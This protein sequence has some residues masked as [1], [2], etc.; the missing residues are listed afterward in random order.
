M[1]PDTSFEGRKWSG[2]HC[3]RLN[4][5]GQRQ[6]FLSDAFNFHQCVCAIE[7]HWVGIL[8]RKRP[9]R[10]AVTSYLRNSHRF[11]QPTGAG[12]VSVIAAQSSGSRTAFVRAIFT[13]GHCSSVKY[14][15]SQ[16]IH[17]FSL[18]V[19]GVVIVCFWNVGYVT[20]RRVLVVSWEAH[21]KQ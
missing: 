13:L 2:M 18:Q 16:P 8:R 1:N 11:V 10:T 5:R 9:R 14:V 12:R 4:L 21:A 15:Y 17:T 6:F 19:D 20:G 7:L 3:W